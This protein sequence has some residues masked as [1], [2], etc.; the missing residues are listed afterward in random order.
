MVMLSLQ[1]KHRLHRAVIEQ[2][3]YQYLYEHQNPTSRIFSLLNNP[4][5]CC[6]NSVPLFYKR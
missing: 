2:L 4:L 6:I 5:R 1:L 3:L